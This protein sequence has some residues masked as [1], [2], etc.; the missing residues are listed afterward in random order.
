MRYFKPISNIT[1]LILLLPLSSLAVGPVYEIYAMPDASQFMVRNTTGGG[2]YCAQVA[3]NQY[4][5]AIY[6]YNDNTSAQ[7]NTSPNTTN[8]CAA[9]INWTIKSFNQC[10]SAT[11]EQIL[12]AKLK[13]STGVSSTSI[14]AEFQ[15]NNSVNYT[16]EGS[17]SSIAND[18]SSVTTPKGP[19]AFQGCQQ[20]RLGQTVQ[21]QCCWSDAQSEC[22]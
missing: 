6:G 20:L 10:L 13:T 9:D 5:G 2:S 19:A 14:S 16:V 18:C 21:L 11:Q 3:P 8:Y 22:F 12:S 7:F 1:A 4:G 15:T 17:L